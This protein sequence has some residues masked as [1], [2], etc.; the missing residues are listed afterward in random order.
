MTV[1]KE[2]EIN[3]LPAKIIKHD[4]L[5]HLCGYIG[6][7]KTHKSYGVDDY[8]CEVDVHGGWTY[9]YDH[10]PTFKPDGFWWLGFD[11]AH[12]G[13]IVPA[14]GIA[15]CAGD[16]YKDEAFVEAELRKAAISF[17]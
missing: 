2:F 12:A 17:A 15:V 1:I 16:T 6:L 11:C 13:D 8:R 14:A 7:P 5:G 9:S 4:S 3:G 10:A